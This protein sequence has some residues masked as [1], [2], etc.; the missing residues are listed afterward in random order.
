MDR[1]R[2]PDRTAMEPRVLLVSYP[3]PPVGGAGV[4]R[5]TKFAKY[6]P[7]AGWLPSVLTVENPSVPVVD[8]S[9]AADIPAGTIVRRARTWEPGYALKTAVS[10]GGQSAG[11]G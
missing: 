7:R 11:R 5:V 9:L 6:L 10:D 8:A 4:Q 2:P 1:L 3:F